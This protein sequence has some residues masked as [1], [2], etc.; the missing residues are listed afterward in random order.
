MSYRQQRTVAVIGLGTFGK[1]VAQELTAVGDRVLGIDID[2][3]RI[4]SMADELDSTLQADTTDIK[5]L[6]Q[7]GLETFDAVVIAIGRVM[8]ASILT[9]V[10]VLELG[11]PNVWVKAQSGTHYKILKAIG[12]TNIVL[13]ESEYGFRLAQML[14]N[15]LV[16]DFLSLGSDAFIVQM[17]VP[18]S[19]IGRT[20]SEL[21][22]QKKFD[23]GCVGIALG[24]NVR[25][26]ECENSILNSGE[27]ML[28]LGS[29]ANI[30]RFA[31]S[32]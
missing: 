21:K 23:V 9:A 25:V 7:C 22:M 2:E 16:K 4:S 24:A 6:K 19:M 14:H 10:N 12:I 1:A 26:T 13:P 5:A 30:R 27:D 20:L 29:R 28:I 31:D 3:G 17:A 18:H 32:L 8:D 15:P 11:F